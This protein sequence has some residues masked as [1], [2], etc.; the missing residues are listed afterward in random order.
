MGIETPSDRNANVANVESD[1]ELSGAE[2]NKYEEN[3]NVA[4]SSITEARLHSK[5]K[6]R[7][8]KNSPRD[9][10]RGEF[11]GVPEICLALPPPFPGREQKFSLEPLEVKKGQN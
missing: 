10:G 11:G 3:G 9:S 8:R 6:R 4:E 5:A 2:Q 7:L 1:S